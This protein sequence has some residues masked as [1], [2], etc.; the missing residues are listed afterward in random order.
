[1]HEAIEHLIAQLVVVF[2]EPTQIFGIEG[3]Y[4]HFFNGARIETPAMWCYEPGP[5]EHFAWL[6]RLHGDG[7]VDGLARF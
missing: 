6:K 1:L 2:T 3:E 7:M 4:L 5:A